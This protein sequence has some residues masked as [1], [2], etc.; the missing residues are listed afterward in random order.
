[1]TCA[2]CGEK[3]GL[4]GTKVIYYCKNCCEQVNGGKIC[5]NCLPLKHTNCK[6]ASYAKRAR[7]PFNPQSPNVSGW[8]NL[9][10]AIQT[11]K[12]VYTNKKS[13]FPS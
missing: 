1:M 4:L 7:A 5:I 2:L 11:N 9:A 13:E 8:A 6:E 3:F 12:I 10:R